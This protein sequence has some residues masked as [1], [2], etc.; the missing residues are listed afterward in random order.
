[1]HTWRHEP[2]AVQCMIMKHNYDMWGVNSSLTSLL[3]S[4]S[5]I[6]L[7]T[8]VHQNQ[9]FRLTSPQD[10]HFLHWQIGV[11]ETNHPEKIL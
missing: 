11:T 1:M 7:S 2:Q 10:P 6:P 3:L 8:G 4:A 9:T 5:D